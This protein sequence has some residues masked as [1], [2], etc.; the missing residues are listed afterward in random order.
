MQSSSDSDR[1]GV[2]DTIKD[3]AAAQI[4]SQKDRATDGLGTMAQAVRQSTQQLREQHH[5]TVASYVE[6]AADHIER[7]SQR[8]RQK[9][10]G[11]CSPTRSNSRDVSPHCLSGQRSRSVSSSPASSRALHPLSRGMEAMEHMAPERQAVRRALAGTARVS[12]GVAAMTMSGR[13]LRCR[14]PHRARAVRRRSG[15][16]RVRRIAPLRRTDDG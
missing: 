8:L 4:N 16:R 13:P 3:R 10:V 15:T 9:D 7:L 1:A 11:T 2:V 14:F 5:E 6:Q 12:V